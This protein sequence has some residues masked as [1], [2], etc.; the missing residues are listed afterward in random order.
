MIGFCNGWWLGMDT[1]AV[2]Q[3]LMSFGTLGT[4]L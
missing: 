2:N 4:K 3:L 1:D